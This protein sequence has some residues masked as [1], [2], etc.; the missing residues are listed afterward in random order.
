MLLKSFD[1]I[2]I[3]HL[4]SNSKKEL[5]FDGS[6]SENV[7]NIIYSINILKPIKFSNEENLAKP[8][9]HN[10]YGKYKGRYNFLRENILNSIA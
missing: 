9:H 8:R 1:K 3:P 7:F 10:R 4:H 2:Y 5:T 6:K